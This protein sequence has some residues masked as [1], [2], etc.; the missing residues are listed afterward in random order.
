MRVS[1]FV[2]CFSKEIEFP[3]DESDDSSTGLGYMMDE[4]LSPSG[5]IASR[6]AMCLPNGHKKKIGKESV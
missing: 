3:G 4:S 1:T 2:L 5:G 6:V